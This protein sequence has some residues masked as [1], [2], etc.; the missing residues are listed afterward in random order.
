[1]MR[2]RPLPSSTS[3][4]VR[5]APRC[6]HGA[7]SS[8]S[9]MASTSARCATPASVSWSPSI[10]PRSCSAAR[11]AFHCSSDQPRSFFAAS[12]VKPR[13]VAVCV[14][15]DSMPDSP[16]RASAIVWPSPR[17]S[18]SRVAAC[19][20]ARC[21][22][23]GHG[24]AAWPA[25]SGRPSGVSAVVASRAS[26][27]SSETSGE[28]TASPS[29]LRRARSALRSRAAR[30]SSIVA[31]V[32]A[33]GMYLATRSGLKFTNVAVVTPGVTAPIGAE[34]DAKY[35]MRPGRRPAATSC[36]SASGA[37]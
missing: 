5:S 19:H 26:S 20:I 2:V 27:A 36:S 14:T 35:G 12:T 10:S 24:N 25:Y 32:H 1:M 8:A 31:S 17:D 37:K 9:V 16:A 22:S 28:S 11:A 34:R 6:S 33:R 15:I 21:G 3:R 13:P 29:S 18:R 4:A 7:A 30:I 23:S